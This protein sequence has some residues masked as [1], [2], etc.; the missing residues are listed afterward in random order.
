[1]TVLAVGDSVS[2]G[3]EMGDLPGAVH[4][5]VNQYLDLGTMQPKPMGPSQ[6]AFPQLL[7]NRMGTADCENLSLI[8]GSNDRTFRIVADR[9]LQQQYDLVVCS[10]TGIDRFDFVY[11]NQ[12]IALNVATSDWQ[13]RQFPWLRS[14]VAD[15]YSPTHMT[16]R[17]YAQLIALQALLRQLNQPY[18]FVNGCGS[19]SL[20]MPFPQHQ[21]YTRHIDT[22]R[23]FM[24]NSDL[25]LLCELRGFATGP[26]GHFLQDGHDYVADQ[27][28][29]FAQDRTV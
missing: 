5:V 15:H 23:Y 14:Y 6:W 21:H 16:Q 26:Q 29:E 8:G 19:A 28:W 25:T 4:G 7:A 2:F 20:G 18:I 27:L 24:P 11:N 1:M 9:V 3:Y 22:S 13:S 12:D 10:W 17:F